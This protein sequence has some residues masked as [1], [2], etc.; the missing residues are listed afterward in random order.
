[1]QQNIKNILTVHNN[2]K[3][4][5]F[6][7]IKTPRLCIQSPCSNGKQDFTCEL[8]FKLYIH[9]GLVFAYINPL[10]CNGQ[11]V[12]YIPDQLLL[13]SIYK[14]TNKGAPPRRGASELSD[15]QKR[16]VRGD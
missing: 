16:T 3:L 15:G 9:N 5:Y 13:L 8:Q 1:M 4:V 6:K 10:L 12:W 7:H 14:G 2:L 11:A